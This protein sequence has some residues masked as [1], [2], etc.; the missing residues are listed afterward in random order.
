M[1]RGLRAVPAGRHV[2][3]A[4]ATVLRLVLEHA[5]APRI[6]AAPH[7]S[8]LIED[9][10]VG[11]AL[12]DG[13]EQTGERVAHGYERTREGAVGAQLDAARTRAAT[14]HAIDLAERGESHVAREHPALGERTKDRAHAARVAEHGECSRRLLLRPP[15]HRRAALRVEHVCRLEPE[16][17]PLEVVQCIGA[18]DASVG[19]HEVEPQA[20]RDE[21]EHRPLVAGGAAECRRRE[22]Q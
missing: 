2:A 22:L 4:P 7:A 17:E 6:G 3:P 11:G 15:A 16:H 21:R 14:E 9:E 19:V 12:D 18:A 5:P 10:R 20:L 13:D 1:P 8:E